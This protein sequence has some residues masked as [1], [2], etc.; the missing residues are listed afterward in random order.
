MLA[1]RPVDRLSTADDLV[2]APQQR[3][4]DVAADE[5]GAAGDE[6]PHRVGELARRSSD[7]AIRRR[8]TPT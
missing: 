2:A 8:P 4:A 6:D 1:R 7:G 3:P 5:A